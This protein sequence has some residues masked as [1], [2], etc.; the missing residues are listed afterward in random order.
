MFE[1]SLPHSYDDSRAELRA[2]LRRAMGMLTRIS[3]HFVV[4][5]TDKATGRFAIICKVWYS[6]HFAAA[7]QSNTYM[8][9]GADLSA[10]VASVYAQMAQFSIPTHIVAEFDRQGR[11]AILL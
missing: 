3:S 11:R 8:H 7:L 1:R 10:T 6:R 2:S 4:T 5:T 9:A